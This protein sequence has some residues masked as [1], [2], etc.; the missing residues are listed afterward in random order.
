MAR[1]RKPATEWTRTNADARAVAS[2]HYFDES[3]AERVRTFA[4]EFC[5]HG[6]GQWAGQP[7]VLQDWQWHDVVAP[8]FGWKRP[9]GSR[10]FRRAHV[11][12][13]KKNGKSSLASALSL[14]LL[15]ADDE[16]GA[17]V[18]N[19][20]V[21]RE[22]ASIVFDAALSMVRQ[23]PELSRALDL[24]PS[25]KTILHPS[26]GSKYL[27]LSADVASKEGLNLSGLIRDELHRWPSSDMSNTLQYAGAARRQPLDITITT[28]GVY[29]PAGVGWQ[30]HEYARQVLDGTIEDTSFFAY[31]RAADP[32]ADWT[33]PQT[34]RAAN[35]SLGVTVTLDELAEQCRA[36]QH[37]V[38]LENAFR[39]YRLNQW[40]QSVERW[41][42]LATFDASAGHPIDEAAYVGR[43]FYGAIDLGAVSDFSAFGLL[44]GC[45]HNP[46]AVDFMLRVFAPETAVRE[47]RNM[48]LY[49]QWQREGY[50]TV[51][52]G[53]ITDE[54]MLM[55]TVIADARRFGCHG[56]T[57]DRLF[58]G[59]RLSQDLAAAGLD[60]APC[61]MGFM[62]MGPL[63]DALEQRIVAGTFHHGG[64]PI[65]RHAIDSVEMVVDAAGSRKPS[66]SDRSKKIDALIAA[67]LAIDRFLRQPLAPPEPLFQCF[68]LGGRTDPWRPLVRS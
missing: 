68:T 14:Y 52:P 6:Q 26:S 66:R 32:A 63:V 40:T 62:S 50:L 35:P 37:S 4:R 39:R 46:A 48:Y 36:A 42:S 11:E 16:P 24:V 29:D 30:Q 43:K 56:V 38:G 53:P 31:I 59:L 41:V 34:W 5:R 27:A 67:L 60:V 8:L 2:G 45:P 12:V 25:R 64:H 28:A 7:F 13:S 44:F 10:R 51:T 18:G 54:E 65:L 47:G 17:V 19:V 33:D 15:I 57:I 21:D 22:Q 23:S 20:A 61:G 55:R 58:Q 1:K 9:D 49:Q 3:A